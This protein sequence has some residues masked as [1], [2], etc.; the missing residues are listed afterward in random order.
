MHHQ[1]YVVLVERFILHSPRVC[2]GRLSRVTAKKLCF[3][4]KLSIENAAAVRSL[5]DEVMTAINQQKRLKA[6]RQ[7]PRNN[8]FEWAK[9]WC[10][11]L[12]DKRL[13]SK[14][15]EVS[16]LVRKLCAEYIEFLTRYVGCTYTQSIDYSEN[17]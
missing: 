3:P 4:R 9:K 5:G 15:R 7:N 6:K 16:N 2:R 10:L 14:R 12:I 1:T 8:L 13:D 11:K 17:L